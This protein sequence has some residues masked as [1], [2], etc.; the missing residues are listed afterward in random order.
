MFSFH[1][2]AL[3]GTLF[4]KKI[5]KLILKTISVKFKQFYDFQKKKH[6]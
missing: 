4:W 5:K 3:F 1:D 2:T 6:C